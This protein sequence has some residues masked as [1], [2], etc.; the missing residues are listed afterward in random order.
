MKKFPTRRHHN[1]IVIRLFN[2]PAFPAILQLAS[3]KLRVLLV[4][5]VVF[6]HGESVLVDEAVAADW[7]AVN[8]IQHDGGV[9]NVVLLPVRRGRVVDRDGLLGPDQDGN[10][11]PGVTPTC[12]NDMTFTGR[13]R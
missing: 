10:A 9:G 12:R 3:P 13:S 8:R 4:L 6:S 11:E 5:E 7:T 1:D 2:W